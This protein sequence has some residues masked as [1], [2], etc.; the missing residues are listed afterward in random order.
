MHEHVRWFGRGVSAP[1]NVRRR[2]RI[3]VIARPERMPELVAELDL[4]PEV[5]PVVVLRDLQ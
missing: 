3:A 5:E 1:V 2:E 4:G